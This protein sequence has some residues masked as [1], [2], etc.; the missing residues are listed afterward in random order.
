MLRD[1]G[2]V[3]GQPAAEEWDNK[4]GRGSGDGP[5]FTGCER[6]KDFP[7]ITWGTGFSNFLR[8][9]VINTE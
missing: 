7:R 8:P 5:F 6:Q 1:D 3:R 2:Q 4:G 9:A